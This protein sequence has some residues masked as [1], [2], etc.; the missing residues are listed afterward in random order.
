MALLNLYINTGRLASPIDA[1]SLST[2]VNLTNMIN[3]FEAGGLDNQTLRADVTPVYA[4]AV[5]TLSSSS[6]VLTATINGVALATSSLSGTD[7]ENAAALVVVINASSNALITGIVTAASA[8]GVVTV[9]AVI[10]GVTANS[11]T[12]TATGTGNSVAHARMTG[13]TNGTSTSFTY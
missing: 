4:T 13:G 6:G 2:C 3:K 7:T 5:Y 11:I 10:P 9:T 1:D 12:T 8:L